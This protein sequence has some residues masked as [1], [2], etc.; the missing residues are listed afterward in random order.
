MPT[1]RHSL[2]YTRGLL[3]DL[4]YPE[5]RRL[6]FVASAACA[7]LDDDSAAGDEAFH[8]RRVTALKWRLYALYAAA[9]PALLLRAAAGRAADAASRISPRRLL[10]TPFILALLF[11]LL[12]VVVAAALVMMR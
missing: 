12:V 9:A 4:R 8:Q 2:G 11:A 10:A 3:N 1:P 7:G 6:R 5:E